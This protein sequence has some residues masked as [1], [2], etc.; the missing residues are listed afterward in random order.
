M[1]WSALLVLVSLATGCEQYYDV[2]SACV[3]KLTGEKNLDPVDVDAMKRINCYRRMV[4]VLRVPADAQVQDAA[5]GE[6]SYIQQNPSWDK[7]IGPLGPVDYLNQ[8]PEDDGYTGSTVYD[9]LTKPPDQGGAGYTFTN[10]ANQSWWEF[11]YV[12]ISDTPEDLPSGSEAVDFLM[13]EPVFRQVALQPSWIDGA[14]SEVELKQ[15]WFL[16]GGIFGD[17]VTTTNLLTPTGGTGPDVSIAPYGRA[18]Y[19]V[20]IYTAP[21]FEHA[22]RPV[23]MPRKDQ[24]DVPLYSWSENRNIVDEFGGYAKTQ[25][26]YPVTLLMGT[27]DPTQYSAVDQNQYNAQITNASIV[28]PEGPMTT[29]IVLPGDDAYDSW[30]SGRLLRTTLALYARDPFAPSTDYMVYAQYTTPAGNYSLQ[31]GFHTRAEDPGVDPTLGRTQVTPGL[32]ARKAPDQPRWM[33]SG[34]F[35]PIGDKSWVQGVMAYRTGQFG[36]GPGTTA[37]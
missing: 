1:R 25:L 27:L 4:G 36:S 23:L 21:H 15:Q 28:G 18:Y 35:R 37:P 2:D 9:R 11:L 29:E 34:T 10:L 13:R 26:S 7:L 20:V 5:S 31:Y 22:D 16:D 17:E 8:N 3:D 12:A 6:T 24:T 30:P 14:Y 32:T 33:T 19:M